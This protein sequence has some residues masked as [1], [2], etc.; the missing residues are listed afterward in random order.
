MTQKMEDEFTES[1]DRLT[2]TSRVDIWKTSRNLQ[3]LFNAVHQ[4]QSFKVLSNGYY[5]LETI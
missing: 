3:T 4:L 5:V 1:V 2:A